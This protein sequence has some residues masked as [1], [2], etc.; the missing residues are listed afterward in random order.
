MLDNKRRET[1]YLVGNLF[2]NWSRPKCSKSENK[3]ESRAVFKRHRGQCNLKPS[4]NN[5]ALVSCGACLHELDYFFSSDR[6]NWLADV[7]V[8]ING[9]HML[10]LNRPPR[11]SS[12]G[13]LVAI[14]ALNTV[15][16]APLNKEH[17]LVLKTKI[18]IGCINQ[19]NS[20]N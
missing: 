4:K 6:R 5:K 1:F 9:S 8:M 13:K 12:A 16:S 19:F 2:N 18:K 10:S 17:N 14:T 20:S 3:T 15:L 11:I 7:N